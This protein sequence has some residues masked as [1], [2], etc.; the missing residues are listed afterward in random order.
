MGESSST[1]PVQ[2]T[3]RIFVRV[4][5]TRIGAA[6]YGL[7]ASMDNDKLALTVGCTFGFDTPYPVSAV[8]QVAPSGRELQIRSEHWETEADHHG[9]LDAFSNRCERV[10]IAA[11]ASRIIYEAE[12]I[13]TSPADRIA[14]GTR[15]TPIMELPDEYIGFLMPS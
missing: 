13:L 1:T 10:T 12:V 4:S 9:Y 3:D 6:G 15:E 2:S 7:A 11:G 5:N 8:L 14:A